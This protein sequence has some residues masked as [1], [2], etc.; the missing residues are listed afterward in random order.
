MLNGWLR[1]SGFARHKDPKL[2]AAG[3][4]A[5]LLVFSLN[6][7]GLD[8]LQKIEDQD[9]SWWDYRLLYKDLW[10]ANK[11]QDRNALANWLQP[12]LDHPTRSGGPVVKSKVLHVFRVSGVILLASGGAGLE[13]LQIW[14]GVYTE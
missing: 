3:A 8:I 10:H 13:L 6:L 14:G 7:T 9:K 12:S 5:D 4:L 11:K 1:Y 2:D